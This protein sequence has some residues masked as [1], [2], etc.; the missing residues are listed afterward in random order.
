MEF[1]YCC[2]I[3]K[4]KTQIYKFNAKIKYLYILIYYNIRYT[5]FSFKNRH[6]QLLFKLFYMTQILSTH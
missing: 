6:L 5:V 4:V 2:D 3:K 1:Q